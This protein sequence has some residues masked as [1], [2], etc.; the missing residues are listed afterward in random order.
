M[1]SNLMAKR[2]F[3]IVLIYCLRREASEW[4]VNGFTY[5]ILYLKD[6]RKYTYDDF[7]NTL[8]ND[9]ICVILRFWM[10]SLG[11]YF[12]QYFGYKKKIELNTTG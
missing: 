1:L 12:E 2:S 10:L 4:R 3:K 6:Y 7:A 9:M 5:C 8:A 11:N